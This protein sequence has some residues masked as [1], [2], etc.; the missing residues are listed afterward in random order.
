[1][2][3][4]RLFL[5]LTGVAVATGAPGFPVP[6]AFAQS[7][8][9]AHSGAVVSRIIVEGAERIEP[10]TVRTYMTLREGE[11]YSASLADASLKAL[12]DTGLFAD[13]T[14][15]LEGSSLVVK[16]IENPIIN[17]V[18]FEGNKRV[19]TT[20]LEGEIQLRPRVVFTEWRAQEDVQRILD[21][22]RRS[23]RFAVSVEPKLIKL[24]QNRVDVVFEINEG[25]STTVKG[26]SFVGNSR[27]KAGE[28]REVIMTSEETWYKFL[29]STDTYDPDR[30]NYDRELLRRFYLKRGYADFEVRSAIAELSPDRQSFFI[31]FTLHEGER[32]RFGTIEVESNLENL[33]PAVL[34]KMIEVK[35]GDWYDAKKVEDISESISEE[36]ANLGYAFVDVRPRVT[37][38][39]ENRVI[40]IV[41]E[42]NEGPRVFVDRIDIQGNVR[43]HDE[44]IRREFLIA[45]GDAFNSSK[46]RRSRQN[47]QDLGF[48]ETVDV[49]NQ[50]SPAAADRTTV[51]VDVKERSTGEV[52]FGIGWSSSVGAL[53]EVGVRERN[54]LGRGQDL[55]A[56]VSWAQ[57]RSQL[58]LGFTEPYFLDRKL[59]AGVDAYAVERDLQDESSYDYR[60][61]GGGV[62]FG[63]NYNSAWS[64]SVRYNVEKMKIEH[65]AWDASRFIRDQKRNTTT[66]LV[67]HVLTY[68]RRDSRLNPTEGYFVSLSNDVAGLGGTEAFLRSDIKAAYYLP[69]G[70]IL[71]WNPAWNFNLQGQAGYIFG[72]GEDVAIN[73]RYFLGGT[74]LRGFESAGAGT[75]DPQT[76]DALGGNWIV[77]GTAE[78]GIPL[79][80]PEDIGITGRLF[81][82]VGLSGKPDKYDAKLMDWDAS[83]RVSV[84]FGLTWVSPVGPIAVDFGF[85][86]MKKDYDE[87]ETLRLSFGSRF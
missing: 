62:R 9:S 58:D 31:T 77:T 25:P 14:I 37:R 59:A 21:L 72:L 64:H 40:S 44:V 2:A 45:E 68:D 6:E 12:F 84:G 76:E 32:Y 29:S 75:R 71:D 79:G 87:T 74:N 8:A 48:F 54:F 11:P 18:V 42:V 5:A 69:V 85:P 81:T 10:E 52:S 23:G 22:Y 67:G 27:F 83:P 4:R 50:P 39:A 73:Q 16:V 80:L 86:I 63:W 46:I 28:L 60:S 13:V 15:R 66:S 43:T 61:I 34:Y 17:Q 70:E 1:M 26:I 24:D 55:R 33:D 57:R 49:S 3:F 53:V 78:L 56:S 41:F 65:V 7:R 82:D 51:V 30:V 47:V 20:A 36:V 38:D 35:N 19:P